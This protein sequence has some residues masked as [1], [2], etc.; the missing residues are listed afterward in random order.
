[1]SYFHNMRNISHYKP[2]IYVYY[3]VLVGSVNLKNLSSR[4]A[5]KQALKKEIESEYKMCS[6]GVH[7]ETQNKNTEENGS[8][9]V[10]SQTEKSNFD[11]NAT[12]NNRNL[13]VG[14][15]YSIAFLMIY[16][17]FAT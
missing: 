6:V 7:L 13:H 11:S 9:L 15:L 1:M 12:I 5:G 3:V 2:L 16:F 8:R 10:V 4:I 17:Y 14:F